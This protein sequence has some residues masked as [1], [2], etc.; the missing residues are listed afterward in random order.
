M[1]GLECCCNKKICS[2]VICVGCNKVSCMNRVLPA[3]FRIICGLQLE[4]DLFRKLFSNLERVGQPVSS[5]VN[6]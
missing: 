5:S 4:M 1:L 2:S 6:K 3:K